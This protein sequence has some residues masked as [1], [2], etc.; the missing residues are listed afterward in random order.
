MTTQ[1]H[2]PDETALR[3]RYAWHK[4]HFE[5]ESLDDARRDA[6]RGISKIKAQAWDEGHEAGWDQGHYE[7][8]PEPNPYR[9][10]EEA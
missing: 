9:D 3:D 10:Q 7:T 5:G 4:T 8:T 1:P 6:E 2:T